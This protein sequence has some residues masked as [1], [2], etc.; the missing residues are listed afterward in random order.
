MPYHFYNTICG[1]RQQEALILYNRVIGFT[2][3]DEQ[4]V[5]AFLHAEYDAERINFPFVSPDF[6]FAAALWGAKTTYTFSQ[7][8]LYREH[9]ET[10]LPL[11]LPSFEGS[12]DACSI[13]SADLCLRFLP[14]LV[15]TMKNIDPED[16]LLPLLQDLLQQWHYS[17]IGFLPAG[18]TL[19][20]DAVTANDCLLQLYT[21]R[22]I[23]KQ[24]MQRA[25]MPA[26]LQK[27][28]G[29]LGIHAPLFWKELNTAI[30]NEQQ[31]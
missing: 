24:D 14:E 25:M 10:E 4:M 8:I 19:N 18:T 13:L 29:S 5:T 30:E 15:P 7:L 23:E 28:K 26:L 27:V 6:N 31:H 17:G 20:M 3:E 2:A 12:I 22:V 21:N 1:L 11:L 16:L 9:N